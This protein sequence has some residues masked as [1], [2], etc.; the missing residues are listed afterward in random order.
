MADK[1]QLEVLKNGVIA[2]NAWRAEHMDLRP[3]LGAAHLVGLD[4]MGANFAGTDLRKADLRGTNLSDTVLVDAQLNGANFF[5]AILDRADL[6]GASLT[7]AQFLTRDQL[8]AARNWQ[9]SQRDPNLACGAPIPP[10]T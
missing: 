6:A 8:M 10:G 1:T 7:G 3:D 5:R 4:L 2:W 9:S